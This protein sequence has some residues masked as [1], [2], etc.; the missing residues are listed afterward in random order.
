M[1]KTTTAEKELELMKTT[2]GRLVDAKSVVAIVVVA[3]WY[4]F[5][6]NHYTVFDDEAF[7]CR[8]YAMPMSRM[9]HLQSVGADPDPP[10]Y[11]ILQNLSVG[12]F[13][14]GPFALR[15]LSI[16]CAL[17]SLLTIRGAGRAWFGDR[18]GLAAMLIAACHPAHL[19]FGFAARWYAMFLLLSTG[20]LWLT[21]RLYRQGAVT[22]YGAVAWGALAA[23]CALTNYFGIVVAA[24]LACPLVWRLARNPEA[25]IRLL[26]AAV[27]AIALFGIWI[28]PF[29]AH[30]TTFRHSSPSGSVLATL[31]RLLVA[32]TTGNLASVNAWWVWAPLA[33]AALFGLIMLGR[34]WRTVAPVAFV[35]IAAIVVGAITRTILDKYILTISGVACVL[36]AGLFTKGKFETSPQK[37]FDL[38][39]LG[40]IFLAVAWLGCGVNL[41]TQRHW[42]SLRWLDPIASTISL[43]VAQGANADAPI[44]TSHPAARYYAACRVATDRTDDVATSR[45]LATI[46]AADWRFAFDAQDSSD[47]AL[48]LATTPAAVIR[49]IKKG[50]AVASMFTLQT[51]GFD[52]L[53]D[54]DA[55]TDILHADYEIIDEWQ[56]LKDDD[57]ALK[58]AIDPSIHHAPWRVTLRHWQRRAR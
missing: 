44:V 18:A 43:A 3:V 51:S 39:R 6:A 9:L 55:L 33:L 48:K 38:R 23:S 14:V 4:I 11:Y 41:V 52:S 30:L 42:S 31:A 1:S 15:G 49:R 22:K 35:L 57:A 26:I 54:W 50:A 13:G 27:T 34:S 5:A 46:P 16:L 56:F 53:P 40:P 10:L 20:L 47:A 2:D 58:D 29:M 17:A 32:L 45:A 8:L 7:S 28:K 37:R 36:L 24:L 12:M 25:R 21:G 19:F